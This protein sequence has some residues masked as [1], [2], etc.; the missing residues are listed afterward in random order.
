MSEDS[1]L[2][3]IFQQ[4]EVRDNGYI[5]RYSSDLLTWREHEKHAVQ[6]GGHLA[7]IHSEKEP[8]TVS[9]LVRKYVGDIETWKEYPYIGGLKKKF[10]NGKGDLDGTRRM[11]R[12]SDGTDF[13]YTP[14][15]TGEP[16]NNDG[17][18]NVIIYNYH[19]NRFHD[20]YVFHG[21]AVYKKPEPKTCAGPGES[22]TKRLDCCQD[23]PLFCGQKPNNGL[24]FKGNCPDVEARCVQCVS[25]Y[26]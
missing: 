24:C 22:C 9:S 11:W 12:W 8:K 26:E 13:D 5:Y 19:S 10:F 3:A 6:W 14:W 1:F 7:S 4:M 20:V 17:I 25:D 23:M 18:G 16:S 2:R 15:N 21:S